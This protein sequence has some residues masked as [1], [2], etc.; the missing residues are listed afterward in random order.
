MIFFIFQEKSQM[1]TK[2]YIPILLVIFLSIC[3]CN[4]KITTSNQSTIKNAFPISSKNLIGKEFVRER[5]LNEKVD[6]NPE[7]SGPGSISFRTQNEAS[8]FAPGSDMG[9]GVIY[10]IMG[11]KIILDI[12]LY[13]EKKEFTALDEKRLKDAE[14][15][16]YKAN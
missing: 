14:G 15:N 4:Q 12:Q 6:E 10:K 16:I 5:K 7:L 11:N 2:K 9:I 1:N 8:Y 13:N 3:S